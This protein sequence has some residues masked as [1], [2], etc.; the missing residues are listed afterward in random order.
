MRLNTTCTKRLFLGVTACLGTASTFAASISYGPTPPVANIPTLSKPM[1]L[2][3]SVILAVLAYRALRNHRKGHLF[4]GLMAL[5]IACS[6]IGLSGKWAIDAFAIGGASFDMSVSGGGTTHPYT[7]AAIE[8]SVVNTSGVTQFI[9]AISNSDQPGCNLTTPSIS[10]C[11]VGL[12]VAN[13]QSCHIKFAGAACATVNQPPSAT[14]LSAAETYTEQSPLNLTNIVVSDVDSANVTAKLTLSNAA[15]GSLTTASAGTVTSTYAA[16]TGIW[17]ATGPIADV[18]TLLAGVTFTPTANF[19]GAF[20]I[21]TEVT[22]GVS[23]ISGLKTMTGVA[24][25]TTIITN[26]SDTSANDGLCTLREAIVASNTNTSSGATPG[27]CNGAHTLIAPAE[28]LT[29]SGSDLS[30]SSSITLSS[31]GPGFSTLKGNGS[32]GI[33]FT[34]GT[35]SITNCAIDASTFLVQSPASVALAATSGAASVVLSGAFT[36][37][38][39]ITGAGDITV[40][41]ASMDNTTTGSFSAQGQ[42]SLTTT[43]NMTNEGALAGSNQL[44]IS[45]PGSFVNAATLSAPLGT[46]SSTG[47]GIS[48]T[49]ASF[50]NNSYVNAFGNIT[51]IAATLRNETPGGDTREWYQSSTGSDTN[52]S[53]N[54]YY[55]FPDNYEIQ[56]WSKDWVQRQRY[57]GGAPAFRPHVISGSTLTLQNF[58]TGTNVG[59]IL[60]APTLTLIGNGGA[61]FTNNDLALGQQNWRQSWEIYTH[62]I[63]LGPATYDDHIRRNDDGG[64]QQSTSEISNIG[65]GAFATT[66]NAGGFSIVNQ[67]APF[68]PF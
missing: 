54:A 5:T 12:G 46:L 33:V 6:C 43:G 15:F 4:A 52:T 45:T 41:A 68:S 44:T 10:P 62:W 21:A 67:G 7:A 1:I 66:L 28:T 40:N 25:G 22:D 56:Y 20:T 9:Y 31:V 64:V 50:T 2:I 36:N 65:A 8:Y 19:S 60:S 39:T 13:G 11:K 18:N 38:G 51:I 63:A 34:T 27:E 23:A 37:N 29:F 48:I 24:S 17:T 3:L 53:T 14:N 26:T 47:G 49:A 59:A 30:L 32:A 61:S 57:V 35:V 42:M 55:S 16:G 58:N